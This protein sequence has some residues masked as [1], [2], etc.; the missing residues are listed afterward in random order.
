MSKST[1]FGQGAFQAAHNDLIDE[2]ANNAKKLEAVIAQKNQELLQKDTSIA[3]LTEANA[4][5]SETIKDLHM[6]NETLL[7]AVNLLQEKEKQLEPAKA[8]K[9]VGEPFSFATTVDY[10][11]TAYFKKQT[12]ADIQT[13]FDKVKSLEVNNLPDEV[14]DL[15][16]RVGKLEKDVAELAQYKVKFEKIAQL[17]N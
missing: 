3:A 10:E 13:L 16:H 6:E 5:L 8:A 1:Y 11:A 12:S 2:M 9:P 14:I 15:L 4:K 17:L 7:N